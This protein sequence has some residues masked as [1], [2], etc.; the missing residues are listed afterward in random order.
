VSDTDPTAGLDAVLVAIQSRLADLEEAVG[1]IVGPIDPPDLTDVRAQVADLVASVQLLN[2]IVTQDV[3]E[4]LEGLNNRLGVVETKVEDVSDY[5]E[6][7]DSVEVSTAE[8]VSL[9]HDLETGVSNLSATMGDVA[10]EAQAA[11][12]KAIAAQAQANDAKGVAAA[13]ANVAAAAQTTAVSAQGVAASAQSTAAAAKLASANTALDFTTLAARVARLE[14]PTP[15]VTGIDPWRNPFAAS[16]PWNRK[17]LTLGAKRND[18]WGTKPWPNNGAVPV[19]VQPA[20]GGTTYTVTCPQFT[21]TGR[22]NGTMA[23]GRDTDQALCLV[24]GNDVYSFWMCTLSGTTFQARLGIKCA[25]DGSGFGT[26]PG[27]KA[28][29]RASGFSLL[30]GLVTGQE[31]GDRLIP[32]AL[33][34]A[35][36]RACMVGTP[37]GYVSPA[38]TADSGWQTSYTGTIWNGSRWAIPK[39]IACPS[40]N[41]DCQTIWKALQDYGLFIGDATRDGLAIYLEQTTVSDTVA[42]NVGVGIMNAVVANLV[43]VASVA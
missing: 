28:G 27:V 12:A 38:V 29:T 35:I 37:P 25:L 30:G 36:P 14:N 22:F 33:A 31:L 2:A 42:N 4:G 16:S 34:G 39:T 19:Y 32:H 40:A 8:A 1:A 43:P 18:N 23:Y 13:A 26:A 24:I 11:D 7:L 41:V 9:V 15:P 6:R 3:Q 5:N 10:V 21:I 17:V 20:S